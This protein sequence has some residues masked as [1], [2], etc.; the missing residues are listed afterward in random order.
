MLKLLRENEKRNY[1]T[2]QTQ[3]SKPSL[4]YHISGVQESIKLQ[5]H[6]AVPSLAMPLSV[7]DGMANDGTGWSP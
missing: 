3:I 7:D 5:T 6:A 4:S 1:G 2:K